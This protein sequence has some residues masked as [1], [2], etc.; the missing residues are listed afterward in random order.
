MNNLPSLY[1]ITNDKFYNEKYLNHND[2]GSIINSFK[3]YFN[4][5]IIAR[6]SKHKLKFLILNRKI[7]FHNF[8]LIKTI[9]NIKLAGKNTKFLFVSLTPF[10]L[11]VF[12]FLKFFLNKKNLYL[13][14]RSNGFSEYKII[15][16]SL[17][18]FFYYL[19]LK[20]VVNHVKLIVS[21][22]DLQIKKKKFN[23][24]QPSELDSEWL[25][26]RYKKDPDSKIKLLYLGRYK[27]EKGIID[28]IKL[29]NLAKFNFEPSVIT[30]FM[31]SA[32]IDIGDELQLCVEVGG[33]PDHPPLLLIMGLGSQLV[34]WP[35]SFVKGL[36]DAGFFVI[37]FDNRDIGLSSKIAR[38]FPRF[39]INN[40]KMMLRMQVGLT[41]RHFPVAYNLFDM[42]EDTRRLLEFDNAQK[43]NITR[44]QRST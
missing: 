29:I 41:N 17:G 30:D 8:F 40:V 7:K 2:L 37:R 28:F 42:V 23:L 43:I 36:I 32:I 14:L 35:D 33:N 10:N 4:I 39:P 6:V 19:M 1:I 12:L 21:S 13:Y 18:K 9:N 5:N 15:L 22:A 27:K 38:P 26:N 31:Q 20:I 3:E 34:F 44:S 16:G 24:V 25:N 11:I